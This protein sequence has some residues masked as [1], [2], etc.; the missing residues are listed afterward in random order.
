M[1]E[2]CEVLTNHAY[3][4][5]VLGSE[6][7]NF[8]IVTAEA[9]LAVLGGWGLMA[10]IGLGVRAVFVRRSCGVAEYEGRGGLV[11]IKKGGLSSWTEGV[12]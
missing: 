3:R 5:R 8:V 7:S 6:I 11:W 1:I 12:L 2:T 10:S 4:D 9:E